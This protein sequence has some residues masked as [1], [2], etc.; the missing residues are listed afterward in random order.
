MVVVS[1]VMRRPFT[2]STRT[3]SPRAVMSTPRVDHPRAR[4]GY[5]HWSRQRSRHSPQQRKLGAALREVKPV[6]LRPAT[7]P[8]EFQRST[9]RPFRV[10]RSAN[11]LIVPRS[12][13]NRNN[14]S[15][16]V[17]LGSFLC[18]G[19]NAPTTAIS[20]AGVGFV[21]VASKGA[22][23]ENSRFSKRRRRTWNTRGA[24]SGRL[25]IIVNKLLSVT[26]SR[27]KT[28][29]S[30]PSASLGDVV[31]VSEGISAPRRGRHDFQP[32]DMDAVDAPSP[33]LAQ[34]GGN[35][36]GANC[37]DRGDVA[38]SFVPKNQ[39]FGT[40]AERRHQRNFQARQLD[41][42]VESLPQ[43]LYGCGLQASLD[44]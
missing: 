15:M 30:L 7:R 13:S 25:D 9:K 5:R 18:H 8:D 10:E 39:S 6:G 29:G 20:P 21:R 19:P 32:L 43:E 22:F 44:Q 27:M 14:P 41:F 33:Q 42:A 3:I 12:A 17:R 1:S 4:V 35:G 28:S 37:D 2:P 24:L 16:G 34:R 38:A 23:F 36:E 31:G 40:H 26:S 11:P